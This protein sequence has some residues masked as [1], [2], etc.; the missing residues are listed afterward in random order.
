MKRC[1]LLFLL[2]TITCYC[3]AQSK[4]TPSEVIKGRVIDSASGKP[5]ANTSVYLNGTYKGTTTDSEGNFMLNSAETNIPLIITHVGYKTQTLTHY[6]GKNLNIV[7]KSKAIELREVTI[8]DDAMS[9]EKEMKIFLTEFI[10][11]TNKDCVISNPGDIYFTWHKK[12]QLL[13]AAADKPLIIYN[14]KLGYKV[15]Y[16]LSAFR[17]QLNSTTYSG[18]YFFAEDTLGTQ[19]RD[20]K[21]ILKARDNAYFGSRMHFIRSLWA[22]RLKEEDFSLD[23]QMHYKDII[24]TGQGQKF[25]SLTQTITLNGLVSPIVQTA[26]LTITYKGTVTQLKQAETNKQTLIAANGFYDPDILWGGDMGA[27]RVSQLLPFEFEP[28]NYV[29]PKTKII[30]TPVIAQKS[31]DS[32]LM[33]L[34]T[35]QDTFQTHHSA[36]KLYL[37]LNKTNYGLD[38]TLWFKAYLFDGLSFRP[39]DKSNIVYVEISDENNVMYM[40][41]IVVMANG[42]GT[43]CIPLTARNFPEGGYTLRA[44]TNWMRNF[45]ENVIYKKQFYI[46]DVNPDKWM[47]NFRL[48]AQGKNAQLHL[49]I[50]QT[51]KKPLANQSVLI[52]VKQGDVVIRRD[53]PQITTATGELDMDVSVRNDTEPVYVSYHKGSYEDIYETPY[54]F[55]IIYN[56]PEKIDVQFM[57]ESGYLVAGIN[58][59]V[60]VK[61]IGE[62]G[63]GINISGSIVNNTDEEVAAIKATNKG[64]GSF[65]FTP[66][67]GVKYKA[68]MTLPDGIKRTYSFP[69][70]K[71]IGTVLTVTNPQ[72]SDSVTIKITAS[73]GI[74]GR[75]ILT[76]QSRG[77]V[78]FAARAALSG[79][80]KTIKAPK[81]AFASGIV[82]FTLLNEQLTTLNERIIYIDHHDNLQI[83]LITDTDSYAPQDSIAL[84]L[85]VKD[86]D[87]DPVQGNFSLSV[88]NDLQL[89]PAKE[90]PPTIATSLLLTSDLK[91]NVEDPEYYFTGD[92]QK[93]LDDL[94]LTQGWTGFD[95]KDLFLPGKKPK[96]VAE[97]DISIRGK[98]INLFDK[99]VNSATVTLLS[100][101]PYYTDTTKTD[102]KGNFTFKNFPQ[103]DSTFLI[104]ARNARGN[105]S[106]YEIDIDRPEWP[107]FT[108]E[109]QLPW[110][111]NTDTT[112][113]KLADTLL[114]HEQDLE[115][116]DSKG[117]LLKEV[118]IK[119]KKIVKGSHNLNGPGSADQTINEED[120]AKAGKVTLL[121]ML[122]KMVIGFHTT[123]IGYF[124][125]STPIK[126]VFD[127]NPYVDVE[128]RLYDPLNYFTSDDILGIEVTSGYISVYEIKY[129]G[130]PNPKYMNAKTATFPPVYIDITTRAGKGAYKRAT[131]P[132]DIVYKPVPVISNQQFYAPAYPVKN[133]VTA[134]N[135]QRTTIHWEP[136]IVT[137]KDGKATL[138]F[139]A[140]GQP[141]TYT[142]TTEGSNMNGNVGSSVQKL[143]I[144]APQP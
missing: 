6:A 114:R 126:F 53:K 4:R 38:D 71:T 98:V 135:D 78:C 106:T 32:A 67:A 34:V 94:L 136:N 87:G 92:H 115:Q 14:K 9:R 122:Q 96:F 77:L 125:N 109:L 58:S 118:D 139:Y 28:S 57:P 104:R 46:S 116:L 39:S 26:P 22:D 93:A 127:G 66:Q 91:G 10:G 83:S 43:G 45:D 99:G 81:D 72:Q 54:K 89:N 30:K 64:M 41:R 13:T 100:I 82:R 50:A 69:A 1:I 44:Y 138:T 15:T 19:P 31:T 130:M 133:S 70:V 59:V 131:T 25:I 79:N 60:G 56:R 18:S 80:T 132:T 3:N 128:H 123:S 120:I 97:P 85:Q 112:V 121:Q 143:T 140:A 113:L 8:G 21:K 17:N 65:R 101:R 90:T 51:D 27:Q 88:I 134:L 73:P 35:L 48:A 141:A 108:N 29:A 36:D 20:L 42:L 40:R 86:S 137:N 37:Q 62:D 107:V 76:G 52:G 75:Y 12:T 117:K 23:N 2:L 24:T 61:A 16:F 5:L 63:K 74:T 7:L 105:T 49:Q 110:Y 124:M 11:S 102:E 68:V 33:R 111:V 129:G 55:P 95:W 119:A 144:K 47:M 84:Q 103:K 142:I